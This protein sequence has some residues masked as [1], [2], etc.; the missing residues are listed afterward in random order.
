MEFA[1]PDMACRGCANAI[2]R[3]VNVLDPA[4]KTRGPVKLPL[5]ARKLARDHSLG[6]LFTNGYHNEKPSRIPYSLSVQR[7]DVWCGGDAG[8]CTAGARDAWHAD[9]RFAAGRGGR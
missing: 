9:V 8:P 5:R 3:A 4:G 7:L 2:T 1:I 6:Q